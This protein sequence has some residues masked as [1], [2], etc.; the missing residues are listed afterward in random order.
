MNTTSNARL[1]ILGGTFNPVH[2]GH[3]ILAQNALETFDLSKVI[4]IPCFSPPHK[5]KT[6]LASAAHRVAMLEA[7]VEGDPRFEVSDIETR[8]QGVSYSVDTVMELR[9]LHPRAELVF[10]VGADSLAELHL[11]K[12]I[13]RL[14]T[15]C[16]FAVFQRPGTKPAAKIALEPPWPERLQKS[17]RPGRLV[18]ISSSDI[19]HRLA[20]GMSIRYLVPSPVE[21]YI[22]EHRLYRT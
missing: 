18:E 6:G 7:A 20:E 2:L 10:I 4:L 15:L 19:R 12:D 3:L 1:G 22:A 11:W 17:I 9:R 21:M 5:H 16:R 14:L 13:G 8:R